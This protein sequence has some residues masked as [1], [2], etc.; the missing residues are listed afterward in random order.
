MPATYS[1]DNPS[2]LPDFNNTEK[3]YAHL[4]S[5]ELRRALFLFQ[6]VGNAK[7]VGVGKILMQWAL[8]LRIPIGWAIRPT[9]YSHF[10]GGETIE[11]CETQVNKL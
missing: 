9:I 8:A 10:C 2:G 4:S 6:T 1:K 5:G 3:A 11:G 7:L